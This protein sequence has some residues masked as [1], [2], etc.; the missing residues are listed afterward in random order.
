[1]FI[2]YKKFNKNKYVIKIN[3]NG[4]YKKAEKKSP[5]TRLIIHLVEPQLGQD[6]LKFSFQ[7]QLG[8]KLMKGECTKRNIIVS[9]TIIDICIIINLEYFLFNTFFIKNSLKFA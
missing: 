2:I 3:K 9:I 4:L 8:V 7:K 1:M 5:C 6:T